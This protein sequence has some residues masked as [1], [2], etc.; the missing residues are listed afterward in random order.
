MQAAEKEIAEQ[1]ADAQRTATEMVEQAQLMTEEA[2]KRL[3][4]ERQYLEQARE[5]LEVRKEEMQVEYQSELDAA[6]ER[7]RA[8]MFQEASR[9]VEEAKSQWMKENDQRERERDSTINQLRLKLGL[10][11]TSVCRLLVDKA[12][13]VDHQM[14]KV[15]SRSLHNLLARRE[16]GPRLATPQRKALS[17]AVA[18]RPSPGVGGLPGAQSSSKS[19]AYHRHLSQ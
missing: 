3:E 15:T 7:V 18:T 6:I 4:D 16:D 13:A 1:R 10:T 2:E 14:S 9:A 11:Q 12:A 5:E 17:P 8:E 19:T